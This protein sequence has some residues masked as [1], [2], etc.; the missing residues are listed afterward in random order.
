MVSASTKNHT[1][2][3]NVLGAKSRL[4]QS[5][6]Q[7]ERVRRL[8]AAGSRAAINDMQGLSMTGSASI[9]KFKNRL[10][11]GK[12]KTAS[13]QRSD[14][15]RS[16]RELQ[17]FFGKPATFTANSRTASGIIRPSGARATSS[18]R[19]MKT[20]SNPG[21]N[22]VPSTHYMSLPSSKATISTQVRFFKKQ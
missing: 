12:P 16:L 6:S 21:M 18:K 8:K 11:S 13:G 9:S 22:A 1:H 7:A 3:S 4:I 19:L 14:I 5:A 15:D 17:E 10:A 20:S 2:R